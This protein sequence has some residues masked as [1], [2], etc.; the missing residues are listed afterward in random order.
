MVL[1]KII[2]V[3]DIITNNNYLNT[4]NNNKLLI[5]SAIQYLNTKINYNIKLITLSI[6]PK[7]INYG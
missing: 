1:Y 3:I 6:S 2:A 7:I 4:K 5:I